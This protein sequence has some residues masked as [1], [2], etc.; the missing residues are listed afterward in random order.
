MRSMHN[1]LCRIIDR[2][3]GFKII[4]LVYGNTY[5][6]RKRD[7]L[8][9]VFKVHYLIYYMKEMNISKIINNQIFKLPI[10]GQ[11]DNLE[12]AEFTFLKRQI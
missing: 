8:R 11:F 4:S 12:K 1:R 3:I 6:V 2:L 5:S 10:N 9:A 7:C